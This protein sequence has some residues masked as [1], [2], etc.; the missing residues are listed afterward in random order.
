MEDIKKIREF[1]K[2]FYSTVLEN[3]GESVYGKI[4]A[5]TY[6]PK[7]SNGEEQDSF[8]VRFYLDE[9]KPLDQLSPEEIIP[10]KIFIGGNSILTDVDD[11]KINLSPSAQ[12]LIVSD[13]GFEPGTYFNRLYTLP[14]SGG[15]S[16][17]TINQF[18]QSAPSNGT[19]GCIVKDL[20]DG[21]P[22]GLTCNHISSNSTFVPTTTGNQTNFLGLSSTLTWPGAST[23]AF[24]Q[25]I[26]SNYA[27]YAMFIPKRA[28]CYVPQPSTNTVDV[29]VV[30]LTG[31]DLITP[32]SRYPLNSRI[33][34]VQQ[35]LPFCTEA[36][37]DSLF[38]SSSPNFAAPVFMSG[39]VSGPI[40]Y[41]GMRADWFCVDG[42]CTCSNPGATTSAQLCCTGFFSGSITFA[43]K[44]CSFSDCI[45]FRSALQNFECSQ[46]GDSG[47]AV[48]VLLSAGMPALSTWKFAGTFFAL[49]APSNTA[50]GL[51]CRAD[52]I[53]EQL[54]V[55]PWDGK[56]PE[57]T[58]KREILNLVS[59][60][61]SSTN[62]VILSGRTYYTAGRLSNS[63]V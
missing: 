11:K 52:N 35:S 5:I 63:P 26:L 8:A 24:G 32:M 53:Q 14:L 3:G 20:T 21:M 4:N 12:C 56:F 58:S 40:G 15:L 59:G 18:G 9:K 55:G 51:F 54:N 50:R 1:I 6:E 37:L 42:S 44:T 10:K 19:L 57:R 48:Y 27:N 60:S 39:G 22:V 49:E 7:I 28:S 31:L 38:I 47:S 2:E 36:E 61:F 46:Y 45:F 41:P 30:S 34:T 62:T 17:G 29:C 43:G 13:L 25:R 33:H 23:P 16:I